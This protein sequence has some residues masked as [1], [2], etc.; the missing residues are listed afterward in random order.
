MPS[1]AE[2]VPITNEETDLL[3]E[4]GVDANR[5]TTAYLHLSNTRRNAVWTD[6]EEH[7]LITT[8][9]TVR[10]EVEDEQYLQRDFDWRMHEAT[11]R[12]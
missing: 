12:R 6:T 9:R 8:L 3:L 7:R 1:Y 5:I 10:D 4:M 11:R 2:L